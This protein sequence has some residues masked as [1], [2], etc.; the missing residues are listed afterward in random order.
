M[1]AEYR[2]VSALVWGAATVA[3]RTA[4]GGCEGICDS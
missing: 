1:D 2:N 3:S 4:L